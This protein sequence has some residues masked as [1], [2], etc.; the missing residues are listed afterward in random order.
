MQQKQARFCIRVI[1]LAGLTMELT[2]D[3]FQHSRQTRVE[4]VEG[5]NKWENRYIP[6]GLSHGL[7]SLSS[8]QNSADCC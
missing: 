5:T 7:L 2:R 6:Q 3:F 8:L 1:I 4:F